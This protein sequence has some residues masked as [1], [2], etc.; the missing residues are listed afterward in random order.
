MSSS[1]HNTQM[2]EFGDRM[3]ALFRA[4]ANRREIEVRQIGV[5]ALGSLRFPEDPELASMHGASQTGGVETVI[6]IG[7]DPDRALRGII[8]VVRHGAPYRGHFRRAG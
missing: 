5:G 8:A 1:F 3:I 6:V 2:V 7:V 4:G